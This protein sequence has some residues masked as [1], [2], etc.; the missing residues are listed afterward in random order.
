MSR[1]VRSVSTPRRE[2]D[3]HRESAAVSRPHVLGGTRARGNA[4]PV[5]GEIQ[6]GRVVG[7]DVARSVPAM[8]AV[9]QAGGPPSFGGLIVGRA[10]GGGLGAEA[11][12]PVRGRRGA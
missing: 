7:E 4:V 6:D 8:G 5:R 9:V 10:G 2:R 12:A 11:A 1:E 3:V